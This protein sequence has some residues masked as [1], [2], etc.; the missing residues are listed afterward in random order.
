VVVLSTPTYNWESSSDNVTWTSTGITVENM[1]AAA[2]TA[3]T[4]YR[5]KITAGGCLSTS[6][7]IAV[8]VNASNTWNGTSGSWSTGSNWSCGS[9]PNISQNIAINGGTAIINLSTPVAYAKNLTL[10]SGAT[11]RFD[12]A[13][14]V[15]R[16]YGNITNQGTLYY[17]NK[18]T[19]EIMGTASH[20][21]SGISD[22]N[23]LIING[24]TTLSSVTSDIQTVRGVLN[25]NAD[26]TTND[27][28]ILDLD[29]GLVAPATT[30]PSGNKLIG[31][32]TTRR[33]SMAGKVYHYISS[34]VS[35]GTSA[36]KPAATELVDDAT[37]NFSSN[38]NLYSY[39]EPKKSAGVN[40]P[41]I[42]ITSA[43]TTLDST[44]GYALYL[45]NAANIDITGVYDHNRQISTPINLDFTPDAQG[46]GGWNLIGNPYPGP[47]DWD[48]AGWNRI[49]IDNAVYFWDGSRG[50]YSIYISG[51]GSVSYSNGINDGSR[52]IPAMQSFL[53]KRSSQSVAGSLT[54]NNSVRVSNYISTT[55][56]YYREQS[57]EGQALKLSIQSG[58]VSEETLIRFLPQA[59]DSYDPSF[60]AGSL[61]SGGQ[62]P[63]LY[64]FVGDTTYDINSLSLKYEPKE[65]LL[66]LTTR[67]AGEYTFNASELLPFDYTQILL[68]DVQTGNVQDLK[69]N[70]IYKFYAEKGTFTNRFKILFAPKTITSTQDKIA[71]KLNVSTSSE[72]L[73][74]FLNNSFEN[75]AVK[76]TDITGRT[77]YF[78]EKTA[79]ENGKCF[80]GANE[81]TPGCLI[82][83]VMNGE[84]S[85]TSK[86][87]VN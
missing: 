10:G 80:I 8:A 78:N 86:V 46:F 29:S 79:L 75:A 84:Q 52:Y 53:V 45:F 49:G 65:V 2:P 60:D 7:T 66:G 62:T 12:N 54:L 34:P 1:P 5:R 74:I 70:N 76:I 51:T 3:N 14:S 64:S 31:K 6:N 36:S 48:N 17:N 68:F 50:K 43:A 40:A 61:G 56:S 71:T 22:F 33:K 32:L 19:V 81:L 69:E 67:F 20:T 85:L 82:V 42:A 38:Y 11:L 35:L 41:W 28:L 21:I 87:I 18:G 23:N 30:F 9:V 73:T 57:E 58:S 16:I 13:S 44:K 83:S 15:L 47:L 26:L 39:S 55:K 24:A 37:I 63:S 27:H 77:V 4:S 25:L 72:G 59:T